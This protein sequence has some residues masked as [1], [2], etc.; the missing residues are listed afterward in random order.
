MKNN[1]SRKLHK[2]VSIRLVK[3]IHYRNF[4]DTI[5]MVKHF[6]AI[7]RIINQNYWGFRITGFDSIEEKIIFTNRFLN[8]EKVTISQNEDAHFFLQTKE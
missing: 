5:I 7:E 4:D 8:K 3:N 2:K 1:P 6:D